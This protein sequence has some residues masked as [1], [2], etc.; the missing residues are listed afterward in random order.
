MT[1]MQI[2]T[3]GTRDAAQVC[4]LSKNGT[5][6]PG[7]VADILVVDGNPL[8]DLTSLKHPCIVIHNGERIR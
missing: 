5:L 1:S 4:G 6:E 3:A 8:Q 2:I 7:K